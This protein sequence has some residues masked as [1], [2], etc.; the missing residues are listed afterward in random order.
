MCA[1]ARALPPFEVAVG[2]RGAALPGR[3][4]IGIH[5]QTHRA[6]RLP[7]LRARVGEDLTE[8]FG[9]GLRAYPH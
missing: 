7:P 4:L 8:P 1:A 3:Q 5:A 9:L 2:R 6:S